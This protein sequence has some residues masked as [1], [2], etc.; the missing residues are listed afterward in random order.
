MT[1]ERMD[2][3]AGYKGWIRLMLDERSLNPVGWTSPVSGIF[4]HTC[5]THLWFGLENKGAAGD[6]AWIDAFSVVRDVADDTESESSPDPSISS[7]TSDTS[8][9]TGSTSSLTSAS[10]SDISSLAGGA[11]AQATPS[12]TQTGDLFPLYPLLL[13]VMFSVAALA[14][15]LFYKR[16]H[17]S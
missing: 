17:S 12:S 9:G 6:T 5:V 16:H 15:L 8:F 3:P 4:E 11:D 2:I 7:S 13:C 14:A 10:N 1:G